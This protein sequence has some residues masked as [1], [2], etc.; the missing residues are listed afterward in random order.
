[1]AHSEALPDLGV[2]LEQLRAEV[3]AR[4]LAEGRGEP[5]AVERDLRRSLDEI[6]LHRVVSAHWP[7]KARTLPGRALV[8]VHKL[9]RRFLRWYINPI[10]EQQNAYNDAV[11]R[12]LRLLAE[13]Y[14][15]LAE[16]AR[17]EALQGG[18]GGAGR[19]EAE[20]GDRAGAAERPPARA[21]LGE[22]RAA[23]L[24]RL[25]EERGRAEHPARFVELE[26]IAAQQQAALRQCVSAHWPLAARGPR[27]RAAALTQRLTRQY[28]RW[29]VNPIV[30]QQNNANAAVTG[31]L[32]NLARLDAE[33]RAEVAALRARRATGDRVTG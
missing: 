26:L 22:E 4:R 17:D 29:L 12:A 3:R 13:A 9:V 18:G 25:V 1:M 32:A 20:S 23:D 14:G 27:E 7:L 6:E 24:Q 10:V 28:L 11:A 21:A 15:E 5:S 16:Q 33:R 8:V 2:I 30:E 19:S 31:A